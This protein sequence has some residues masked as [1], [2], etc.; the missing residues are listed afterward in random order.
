MVCEV[1]AISKTR[2]SGTVEEPDVTLPETDG[3]RTLHFTL[4]KRLSLP[5]LN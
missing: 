4:S 2:S 3:N 1:H 5:V